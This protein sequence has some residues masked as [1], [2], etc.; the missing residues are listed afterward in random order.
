MEASK[1]RKRTKESTKQK[2]FVVKKR[3]IDKYVKNQ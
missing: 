2:L 3:K 1:L